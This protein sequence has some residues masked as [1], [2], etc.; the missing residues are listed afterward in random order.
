MRGE[1]V[2]E[3]WSTS[4]TYRFHLWFLMIAC[5]AIGAA[6]MEG[7]HMLTVN[8]IVSSF[9]M[10]VIGF[11]SMYAVGGWYQRKETK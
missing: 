7:I 11:W 1:C 9:V 2:T 3:D 6:A 4:M 8:N 5:F 10:G